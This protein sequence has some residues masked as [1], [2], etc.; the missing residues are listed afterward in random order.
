MEYQKPKG[1]LDYD[2]ETAIQLKKIINIVESHFINN[3]GQY[4]ETPVF[5]HKDVLMKKY[6][7]EEKLIYEIDDTGGQKL[8][9]RYDLTV[10]FIRW[11]IENK[12]DKIR[13]Y[14]IGKVYRRDNP[15]ISQGRFREFYQ[16]DFDILGE[17]SSDYN[18]EI[19][20]LNMI[21][22]ILFDLQINDFEIQINFTENLYKILI[23]DLQV[24]KDKF[25][26]ICSTID[27]LDKTSFE[28]LVDEF[29]AKSLNDDQINQ[30]KIKLFEPYKNEKLDELLMI[31]DL[32]KYIKYNQALARGLDYYN[33][34]IF[35]VKLK[36]NSSTIIAGGRYNGLINNELIGFSIGITRL[37]QFIKLTG[38]IKWKDEYYLAC[39]G[40]I[41]NKH[42]HKLI[43][44]IQSIIN[45]K[46]FTYSLEDDKKLNKIITEKVKQYIKYI[47]IIGENEI[48]NNIFIIKDLETSTQKEYKFN[49]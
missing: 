43:N 10:P 23:D 1:T 36:N 8:A 29:K 14:S 41:D 22:N 32:Q 4:L 38:E 7:D 47:I 45:N 27:K 28:S 46:K 11:I 17:K 35:E 15:N 39:I 9:L 48:K 44:H 37:M 42:K 40:T 30:L 21:K 33:G 13:R 12:I 24:D 26:S 31:Y 34:I 6:N 3:G 19:L 16:G 49:Y 2:K 25:R 5:E 18:A 20:L